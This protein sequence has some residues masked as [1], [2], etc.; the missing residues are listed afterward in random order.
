MNQKH[1]G[2][3]SLEIPMGLKI[4]KKK[5]IVWQSRVHFTE[6]KPFEKEEKEKERKLYLVNWI[7]KALLW[8]FFFLIL[9]KL[10]WKY[11]YVASW[12]PDSFT[13]DHFLKYANILIKQ[14]PQVMIVS[15]SRAK[16]VV[17]GISRNHSSNKVH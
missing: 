9:Q 7:K 14:N 13:L 11:N 12:V 15:F 16:V 5:K 6:L 2:W 3:I 4:K 17:K 1:V 10:V 8:C